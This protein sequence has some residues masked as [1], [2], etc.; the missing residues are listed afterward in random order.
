M[1]GEYEAL[2][3]F[4]HPSAWRSSLARF[5]LSGFALVDVVARLQPR[6]VVDAGCGY[7]EFKGRIP[8][9]LGIDL[10]N[11]AAD[12]VCD[13]C[14][15]PIRDRSIDVVLALGSVN[16]GDA[17]EIER[18]LAILVGWLVPYGVLLMRGNPGDALDP[19]IRVFPWSKAAIAKFAE[20][21]DLTVLEI[22]EEPYELP[23]G[24]PTHR[25]FWSYR[26]SP[27]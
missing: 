16:F 12:L 17:D 4:F 22:A 21:L 3:A 20:R 13:M 9:L 26:K 1:S 24:R 23:D 18:T 8:N 25:L 6:F 5:P 15:A 7:N 10:V 14:E 27:T 11:P 19:Q 2:R